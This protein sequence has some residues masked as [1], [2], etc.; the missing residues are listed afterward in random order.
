MG[1]EATKKPRTE[2]VSKQFESMVEDGNDLNEYYLR[3]CHK[4]QE[5]FFSSEEKYPFEFLKSFGYDT[6]AVFYST[7]FKRAIG[8]KVIEEYRARGREY[9]AESGGATFRI[10]YSDYSKAGSWKIKVPVAEDEARSATISK[11]KERL[12]FFTG[13]EIGL[14]RIAFYC[15]KDPDVLISEDEA[16]LEATR[17]EVF[18]MILP[19]SGFPQ[20]G[21]WDFSGLVPMMAAFIA[22]GRLFFSL[23]GRF[24]IWTT[25]WG[26]SKMIKELINT[27]QGMLEKARLLGVGED[28][29]KEVV[30]YPIPSSPAT[31][32]IPLE[33]LESVSLIKGLIV[34]MYE[35][36][37]IENNSGYDLEMM[38]VYKTPEYIP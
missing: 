38:E 18:F 31:Q 27:N 4:P 36:D 25:V 21:E 5:S 12:E 29:F 9:H 1:I 7:L 6:D 32:L 33:L 28:I 37:M 8:S 23:D 20:T 14:N 34:Y 3:A 30:D 16:V 22:S 17:K 11:F 13:V 10:L 19:R 2:E 26:T 15:S 24:R 35:H